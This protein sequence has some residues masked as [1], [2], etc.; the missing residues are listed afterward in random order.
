MRSLLYLTSFI[1]ELLGGINIGNA[2]LFT[3][4]YNNK[5]GNE[6]SENMIMIMFPR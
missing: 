4:Y 6:Q 5:L 3:V 1:S 2:P